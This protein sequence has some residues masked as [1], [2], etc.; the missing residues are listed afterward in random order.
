M[1]QPNTRRTDVRRLP[2]LLLAALC[3]CLAGR[4]AAQ[5]TARSLDIDLSIR[6]SGMGGASNAV[7]WGGDPNHWANPA[8]LGYHRGAAYSWGKTQLVPGLATDVIL[9]SKRYTVGYGGVGLAFAGKGPGSVRLDYGWSEG[10]DPGGN[11]TGPFESYEA[12]DSWG[13]GFSLSE[14]LASWAAVHGR[15]APAFAR[16]VDVAAGFASKDVEVVLAPVTMAGSASGTGLDLGVLL[17]ASPVVPRADDPLPLRVDLGYAYSVLNF[18][19]EELL[20]LNEDV[21]SPLTRSHRNGVAARVALGVPASLRDGPSPA[22]GWLL[23][24]LDPL[25]SIGAA[26]DWEHNSA[27][28]EYYFYDV[29]R[30]G[31]EVTLANLLTWRTGHVTDRVGD[32]DG[33]TSGWALGFHVGRFAGFRYDRAKTPQASDSGL[34]NV[35]REGF[36]LFVD[37]AEFFAR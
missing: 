24:S 6:S 22:P 16:H 23:D 37:V 7:F 14:A 19:N 28:G 30:V 27:G 36:T 20:F 17:R 31:V 12:I 1:M 34:P 21:T 29:E 4:A 35:E 25:V 5:G 9:E 2:L 8:L 11:P 15:P 3:L 32:I 10:T 18:N 26:R 33:S 13:I